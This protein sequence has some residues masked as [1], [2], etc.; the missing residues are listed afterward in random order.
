MSLLELFIKNNCEL[1]ESWKNKN[2]DNLS[3]LKD[4][5]S[6]SKEELFCYA[7]IYYNKTKR[8][9]LI[10]EFDKIKQVLNDLETFVL[11]YDIL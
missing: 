3:R 8:K 2:I 4:I 10:E 9:G 6:T 7:N 1:L 5:L 11:P